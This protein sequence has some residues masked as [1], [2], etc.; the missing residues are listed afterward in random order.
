MQPDSSIPLATAAMHPSTSV[1]DA[2]ARLAHDVSCR[3]CGYNLRG[4]LP[5]ASCPECRAP[6][7]QSIRGELLVFSDPTWLERISLGAL[8][9]AVTGLAGVFVTNAN[10]VLAAGLFGT[11]IVSA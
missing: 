6:I 9:V 2:E 1:L 5:S 3:A 7:A 10:G 4:L 11:G 8:L